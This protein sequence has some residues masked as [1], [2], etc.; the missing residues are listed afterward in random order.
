MQKNLALIAALGG[1]ALLGALAVAYS[2]ASPDAPANGAPKAAQAAK[3]A[4]TTE[5]PATTVVKPTTT[6]F[7]AGDETAIREI[8][9]AYLLEHPEVLADA[10]QAYDRKQEKIQAEAG[11]KGVKANLAELLSDEDGYRAGKDLSKAR[12]AVIE[13]FDYHCGYCKKALPLVREL[14]KSDP[15][16][17]FVFRELPI[18]REESEFAAEAALAARAQGKYAELHFA[19]MEATGTLTKDRIL[20]IARQKGLDVAKLQ[21]DI[22]S[23]A[24]KKAIDETHRIA[25]E[26]RVDGTP[27]FIVTTFDGSYVEVIPGLPRDNL[28]AAIAA[29]K[30]AAGVK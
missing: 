7:N 18:L 28:K 29:A 26:M 2:N 5:A 21:A 25:R 23:P 15:A 8:V 13:L 10:A 19:M 24:V 22:K 4:T 16:V 17:K 12:V 20:D 11:L 14:T 6:R 30:K 3:P 27:A 1:A 9:R